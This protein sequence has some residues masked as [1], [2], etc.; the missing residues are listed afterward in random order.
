M[1]NEIKAKAVNLPSAITSF[2]NDTMDNNKK[3]RPF[4]K[5]F[6]EQ[7]KPVFTKKSV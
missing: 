3:I 1:R 2:I 6:W 5:L 4:I 7:Q